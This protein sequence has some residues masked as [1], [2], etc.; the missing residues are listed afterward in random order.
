[1]LT[2]ADAIKAGFRHQNKT[3]LQGFRGEALAPC[4]LGNYTNSCGFHLRFGFFPHE[5]N[6]LNTLFVDL[7]TLFLPEPN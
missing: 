3:Q 2:Y 1:M 4:L 7:L 5:K 6:L